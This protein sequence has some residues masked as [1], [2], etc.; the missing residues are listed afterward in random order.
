MKIT[1]GE[2]KE[3]VR[4]WLVALEKL[5][6][7]DGPRVMA[8]AAQYESDLNDEDSLLYRELPTYDVSFLLVPNSVRAKRDDFELKSVA[9]RLENAIWLPVDA[10]VDPREYD[11]S[12]AIAR[13]NTVLAEYGESLETVRQQYGE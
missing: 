11:W 7:W 5:L 9:S 3:Y 8:W 13:I 10:K 12:A 2:G 6:G 1:S 4:Y